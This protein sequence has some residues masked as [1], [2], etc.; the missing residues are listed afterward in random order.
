MLSYGVVL[1]GVFMT[2]LVAFMIFFNRQNALTD[3][4][5]VLMVGPIASMIACLV[6]MRRHMKLA[7]IP[8]FD[9]L[10][11]MALLGLLSFVCMLLLLKTRIIVGFFGSLQSLLVLFAL[12]Y[13]AFHF[14]LRLVRR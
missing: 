11:G 7:R 3:V 9:N 1:P 8:G 10:A 6:I 12:L 2:L 5:L 4:D 14:A 13:A